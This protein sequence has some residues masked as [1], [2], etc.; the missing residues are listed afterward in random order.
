MMA[1]KSMTWAQV[2]AESTRTHTHKRACDSFVFDQS[3]L[4]A[5]S[6]S[7]DS[8]ASTVMAFPLTHIH[9]PVQGRHMHGYA[10]TS[11]CTHTTM[12]ILTV[13]TIHRSFVRS[14]A[15]CWNTVQNGMDGFSVVF[16]FVLLL[17]AA[18]VNGIFYFYFISILFNFETICDHIF[19]VRIKW[20]LH[21][22]SILC[23]IFN[24]D[25]FICAVWTEQ[26][27]ATI[28]YTEF[29]WIK[30]EWICGANRETKL[31]Y[32]IWINL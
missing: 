26:F 21:L 5:E 13:P 1:F 4:H 17:H 22:F 32:G 29:D 30:I 12:S 27:F 24:F 11:W 8:F 19:G 14:F 23:S 3:Q 15:K 10:Y 20:V 9:T 2:T 6:K 16:V 18:K 31:P 7:L 25:G 28:L